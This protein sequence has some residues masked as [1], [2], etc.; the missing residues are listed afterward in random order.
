MLLQEMKKNN[1]KTIKHIK[2]IQIIDPMTLGILNVSIV[3][4]PLK[5]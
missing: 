3:S 5:R 1:I 2:Q 4:P